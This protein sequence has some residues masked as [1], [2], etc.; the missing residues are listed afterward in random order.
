[1]LPLVLVG[2]LLAATPTLYSQTATPPNLGQLYKQVSPAV[3]K[4]E[5]QTSAG[6]KSVGSGFVISPEGRVV[7][8]E[9]VV[10]NASRITVRLANGDAFD[11]VEVLAIDKR[12]DLVIL[13][14]PA[15]ELPTVQ[16]GR[17]ASVAVGNPIFAV[18]NPLGILDNTLSDG[19]VSGVRELDGYRVFQISCAISKGSSGG[20]VFNDKGEVVG[21]AVFLIDGGQ[22]LNFAV[23]VDYVRG[24]LAMNTQPKGLDALKDETRIERSEPKSSVKPEPPPTAV[25]ASVSVSPEEIRKTG[26]AV[27]LIKQIG[28]WSP[29]DA[30]TTL[31]EPINHRYGY[32]QNQTIINNI[33]SYKDPLGTAPQMEIVFNAKTDKMNGAFLYPPGLTWENIKKLWGDKVTVTKNPDGTKFHNY[34]AGHVNVKLD[35][36]NNVLGIVIY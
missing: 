4:V 5:V 23:P 25:R 12:R 19:I 24:M 32:D 1:M 22:S 35:K 29:A 6:A 33:Y 36:N 26:L 18:S 31:G 30:K 7:T 34:K 13:K 10:V 11:N 28:I 20:P 3:V 21:V 14:I 2:L 27:F 8:N 17:S 9:H 16:L 15:L